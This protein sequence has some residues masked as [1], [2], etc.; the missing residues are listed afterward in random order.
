MPF[1]SCAYWHASQVGSM[2][3]H[4]LFTWLAELRQRRIGARGPAPN[5]AL[6]SSVDFS[7]DDAPSVRRYVV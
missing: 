4:A 7:I 1:V 3:E 2:I 5:F 6:V